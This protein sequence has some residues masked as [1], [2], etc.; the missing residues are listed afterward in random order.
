MIG[1]SGVREVVA[2]NWP[3]Y[4][5][6]LAAAAASAALAH[7]LPP[8]LRTMARA[9]SAAAVG[10]L[11]SATVASWLV[12]DR[13]ELYGYDW[14][15]ALLPQ[16]PS[17]H[18]VVGTGLDEASV[19]LAARWP[20]SRQTTVDLYDPA[21]MTEGSVRRARR[22]V[23]PPPHAV[24]GRAEALPVEPAM[25]DAVFLVFAA[26]E[27]RR[28]RDRERL[29]AQCARALRPGGRLVLVEHLR[30]GANTAVFGPGAWHFFP[31]GEWLRL[32]AHAGLRPAAERRVAGLVTAFAFTR[33]CG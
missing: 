7:R 5:A 19:P 16:A 21:V 6:G 11:A 24:P 31:R 33:E 15:D 8:P 10:L 17:A 20:A 18:V 14:L 9:G 12:Y 29:F 4:T 3:R 2:Y 26:H 32:A 23:P 13:S 27:L 30:D 1:R 22:R 25:A 28:A